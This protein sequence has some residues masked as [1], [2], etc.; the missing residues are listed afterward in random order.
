MLIR[1]INGCSCS[2]G[3]TTTHV[4]DA[5]SRQD[6]PPLADQSSNVP[7]ADVIVSSQS[8]CSPAGLSTDV[9][10]LDTRRATGSRVQFAN[11]VVP[12]QILQ[13]LSS[14]VGPA[15]DVCVAGATV[16][17]KYVQYATVPSQRTQTV[18]SQV[19]PSVVTSSI[20]HVQ[21]DPPL[22][23][24]DSLLYRPCF[25]FCGIIHRKIERNAD[26]R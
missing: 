6:V 18:P 22:I 13:D 19:E 5:P 1:G 2:W 4:Y 20:A 17:G 25:C 12:R 16:P 3:H 14:H 7:L 10:L 8:V 26:G 23:L 11:A 15:L 9:S 21:V 24:N